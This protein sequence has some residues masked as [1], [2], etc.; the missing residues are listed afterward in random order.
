[1]SDAIQPRYHVILKEQYGT[2]VADFDNFLSLS[3]TKVVN[4][5]S[6]YQLN[7]SGADDR[8]SLFDLDCQIEIYRQVIGLCPEYLEFEGLHRKPV[9]QIS[10]DG[11]IVFSS[12]GVGYNDFLARTSILYKEGTIRADKDDYAERAMKEYVEENCGITA[13]LTVVGRLYTGHLY[14]FT[15]EDLSLL[16]TTT[17]KWKGAKAYQNLLDVLNEIAKSSAVDFQVVGTGPARFRFITRIGHLGE[18]RSTL[19]MTNSGKNFAGNAPVLF[20]TDMGNVSEMEHSID[21]LGE[22]TVCLVLGPGEG[23]IRQTLTVL[24]SGAIDDSPWNR[25]EI[26]RQSDSG[27]EV[28]GVWITS[29]AAQNG[30]SALIETSLRD[31]HEFKPIQQPT[32]LYGLHY[33]L[34][35]VVSFRDNGI[36]YHKRIVE[37]KLDVQSPREDVT[38]VFADYP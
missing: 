35:D 20:G 24:N 4:G 30:L 3:V 13:D 10:N 19:A 29:I 6:T 11:K 2:V 26:V 38:L 37:V 8:F 23:S 16:Y 31:T 32:C 12:I 34:G 21:R 36:D 17:K 14:G 7:F 22:A 5:V 27:S 1:M 28:A 15:V 9:Y 33:F 25:R 18:D